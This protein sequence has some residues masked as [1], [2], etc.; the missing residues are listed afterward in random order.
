MTMTGK[1]A[2]GS[3]GTDTP[4]AVLADRPRML[5]DYFAQLFA[6]VTNPPLDTIREELVIS[7]RVVLGPSGNIL[8]PD[9][10]WCQQLVLDYPVITPE[11]LSRITAAGDHGDFSHF[12]FATLAGPIVTL[13]SPAKVRPVSVTHSMSFANKPRPPSPTVQP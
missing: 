4:S 3:M 9:P 12:R 7:H 11:T 10:D 1:V 8:K 13:P 6:Q 2:I 5:S